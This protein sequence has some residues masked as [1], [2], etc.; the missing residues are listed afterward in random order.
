[1][2]SPIQQLAD[3]AGIVGEFHDIWGT[4]H[5]TSDHSRRGLLKAMGIACDN[6]AEIAASLADWHARHWRQ[7]LMP[8]QA[9]PAGQAVRVRLHLPHYEM[10]TRMS[11]RLNFETAETNASIEGDLL[12][13]DLQPI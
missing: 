11:W 4:P 2:N 5:A 7:R 1:M 13:T 3:L 12:P 6:D 8:V 9:V 10:A